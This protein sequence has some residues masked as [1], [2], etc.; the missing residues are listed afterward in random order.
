ML[1]GGA[2]WAGAQ[3]TPPTPAKRGLAAFPDWSAAEIR[4]S[5][6][7]G[8]IKARSAFI[9]GREAAWNSRS[10]FLLLECAQRI[11]TRS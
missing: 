1:P 3:R 7:A 10:E 11:H 2:G 6:E 5:R 9:K 8:I 4:D